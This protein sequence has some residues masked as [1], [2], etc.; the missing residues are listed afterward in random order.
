MQRTTFFPERLAWLASYS[1]ETS[2][3][4]MDTGVLCSLLCFSGGVGA[5]CV[6]EGEAWIAA[7]LRLLRMNCRTDG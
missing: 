7:R 2:V 1:G 4:R 6:Q 3:F 5:A